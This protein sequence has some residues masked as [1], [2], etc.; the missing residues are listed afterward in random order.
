MRLT[1]G[2]ILK[3]LQKIKSDGRTQDLF[4]TIDSVKRYTIRV[5]TTIRVTLVDEKKTIFVPVNIIS[6]SGIPS[7]NILKEVAYKI[8]KFEGVWS[9]DEGPAINSYAIEDFH[10]YARMSDSFAVLHEEQEC[11][12]IW[13]EFNKKDMYAPI[14]YDTDYSKNGN[15]TGVMRKETND[16]KTY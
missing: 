6:E 9:Y 10:A 12:I 7:Q 13:I 14:T 15:R 2:A 1:Y 16:V 11:G 8:N 4:N 3:E 5:N